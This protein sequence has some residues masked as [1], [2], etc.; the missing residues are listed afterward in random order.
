MGVANSGSVGRGKAFVG[1]SAAVPSSKA[2]ERASPP[3]GAGARQVIE[4]LSILVEQGSTRSFASPPRN[5]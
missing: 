4:S 5:H 3:S 1:S 2:P